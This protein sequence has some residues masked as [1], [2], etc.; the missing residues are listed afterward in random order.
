MTIRV[1]TTLQ[2]I[3]S[4][5]RKRIVLSYRQVRSDTIDAVF[6]LPLINCQHFRGP[7]Y[8]RRIYNLLFI[9][10]KFLCC[11]NHSLNLSTRQLHIRIV[12]RQYI[13]EI[14]VSEFIR[15]LAIIIGSE[16]ANGL[17]QRQRS[18]SGEAQERD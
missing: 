15:D 9:G 3:I 14:A 17:F 16:C 11:L 13:C 8:V 1:K 12:I 4:R 7:A 6:D 18:Q 10:C 5:Q 2:N